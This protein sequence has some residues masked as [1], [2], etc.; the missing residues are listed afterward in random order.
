M[1]ILCL[2]VLPI[3]VILL[4]TSMMDE[5]IPQELPLGIV[6]LDNT[7]TTRSMARR[8]DA[9]QGCKVVGQYQNMNEARNAVQR[10][11]IYGFLLIPEGTTRDL[12]A[13][14]QPKVTYYYS[15]ASVSAGSFVFR[16]LKTISL[17]G[18]AAV[19]Q[20]T[21][22][23]K[24]AT[25]NQIKTFLQPIAL[26]IH[27]INNPW[28]NYNYYLSPWLVTG[29]I[30]TFVFLLSA[31][32]LGQEIKNNRSKELVEMSGD[33][34][35]VLITGKYLP[36]TI[37]NMLVFLGFFVYLFCFKGFPHQGWF[38]AIVLAFLTV[39][40]SEGFGIFAF[41]LVPSLRLSM[42]I[43]SLWAVLSFSM[44]GAALPAFAMDA[45]LISLA[46]LFPLRHFELIYQVSVF[47]G[48]PLYYVISNVV[49]LL[50][51]AL[52]PFFLLRRIRMAL[53]T[54]DYMD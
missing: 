3:L 18:S 22:S 29:G 35:L 39:L 30:L 45:P 23:A 8:L 49:A 43:C 27:P 33:N 12:L 10:G 51:F 42:S 36:Y 4:Y 11:E 34:M 38:N 41:G 15:M 1:Y 5:G 14:R 28:V 52:L 37:I 31:Y 50:C 25:A 54:W 19:G 2:F 24:G 26:D 16:D 20:A 21:L 6:D 40:A 46:Q 17:L 9:F 47:N 44:C 48:Y 53:M 7:S 13:S 32:S